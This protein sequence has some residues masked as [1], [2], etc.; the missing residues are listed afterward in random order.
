MIKA[1]VYRSAKRIF[2]CKILDS[3]EIVSATALG[4]LLKREENIVV[5]DFVNLEKDLNS[6]EYIIQSVEQ[7]SNEIFRVIVREGKKKVSASNIDVLAIVI[8][9]N[10]PA[11][12]RGVIDRFLIR[13]FQWNIE[14][15]II[16]NKMDLFD[17]EELDLKF[18]ADRFNKINAKCFEISALDGSYKNRFLDYGIE[19][20]KKYVD[21]KTTMFAGQSGV[22]K[23]KTI[24]FLAGLEVELKTKAVGKK[25]KGTHTTT[26]SEIID[27]GNIS[28][29]DSPGI[30]SL[31]LEDIN[32]DELITFFPDLAKL[33]GHCK[34]NNCTHEREAKGCAY[35]QN[36]DSEKYEDECLISRLDSYIHIFN[37]LSQVDH[38]DSNLKSK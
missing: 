21:G 24:N 38:W 6:D 27:V 2:E 28:L 23:S 14:P 19:D 26:W 20:L 17:E 9:V 3:G 8:S 36:L 33:Y 18:E 22:G 30:R 37:E 31:A 32:E 35:R 29:I 16:F 11:Y 13:A 12:K 5:G 7:R 15:I 25:G 34:F 10:R 4:K 1:R